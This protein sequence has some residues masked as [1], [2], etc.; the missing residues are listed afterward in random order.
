VAGDQFI[1]VVKLPYGYGVSQAEA[2]DRVG[3]G[4]ERG[5]IGLPA[6]VAVVAGVNEVHRDLD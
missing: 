4:A 2:V 6:D 1:A 5:R 3:Q